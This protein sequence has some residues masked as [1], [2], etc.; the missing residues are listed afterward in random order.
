MFPVFLAAAVA[1]NN[2]NINNMNTMRMINNITND[3]NK[4][5]NKKVDLRTLDEKELLKIISSKKEQFSLIINNFVSS[6]EQLLKQCEFFNNFANEKL[7]EKL[8]HLKNALEDLKTRNE[9][10]YTERDEYLKKLSELGFDS[11]TK[12]FSTLIYSIKCKVNGFE[13]K[14]K[15]IYQNNPNLL[16]DYRD[17][18]DKKK[19]LEKS[20]KR[21]FGKRLYQKK[22]DKVCE[23]FKKIETIYNEVIELEKY[24]NKFKSDFDTLKE[25]CE[26]FLELNKKIVTIKS[27]E[28]D[29]NLQSKVLE[30]YLDK[31]FVTTDQITKFVKEATLTLTDKQQSSYDDISSSFANKILNYNKE[32]LIELIN[33]MT[34]NFKSSTHYSPSVL[35]LTDKTLENIDN[36]INKQETKDTDVENDVEDI[37]YSTENE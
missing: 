13:E 34:Y 5:K 30:N 14:L 22:Y 8:N 9:P 3:D 27:Q 24:H 32:D 26:K 17:L 1:I 19:H 12:V 29:L 36:E 25:N 11:S 20:L 31:R 16:N 33:N 35:L 28:K 37:S 15:E 18:S 23:D 6:D 2:M 4:K 10:K 7:S 21:P